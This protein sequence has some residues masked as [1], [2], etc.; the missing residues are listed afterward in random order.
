MPVEA[1][2]PPS[3]AGLAFRNAI[4]VDQGRDFHHHLNRLISGIERVLKKRTPGEPTPMSG[5]DTLAVIGPAVLRQGNGHALEVPQPDE[6]TKPPVVPEAKRDKPANAFNKKA[7][8]KTELLGADRPGHQREAPSERT[9][10]RGADLT[11]SPT[12]RRSQGAMN[13]KLPPKS[14]RKRIYFAAIN[15]FERSS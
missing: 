7:L 11:A 1:E 8:G 5:S 15:L 6:T 9:N 3:L 2:L 13:S 14:P 4:E 12:F 10:E